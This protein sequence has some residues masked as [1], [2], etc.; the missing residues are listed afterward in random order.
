MAKVTVRQLVKGKRNKNQAM[1]VE[2]GVCMFIEETQFILIQ[3]QRER[4]RGMIG[5][6][7]RAAAPE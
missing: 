5:D 3:R 4:E 6:G 7:E 1:L 2:D